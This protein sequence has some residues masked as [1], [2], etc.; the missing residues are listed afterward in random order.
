MPA[1]R[2]SLR[3]YR[4]LGGLIWVTLG[5]ALCVGGVRLGFGALNRPESGFMSLVTGGLLVLLGLI[6]MASEAFEKSEGQVSEEI[7]EK[8]FPKERFYSI[9]ALILYASLLDLLG[10]LIATFL[11]LLF[12]LR[13]LSPQ[14]WLYHIF[15]SLVAVIL[16]FL[17]FRVWLQIEFPVG[18]FHIG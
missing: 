11:F 17:L 15:I 10:F 2:G 7:S 4:W 6:S 9:L 1:K 18:V 5:G 16:S 3:G 14:K 13:V 12:L 8:R